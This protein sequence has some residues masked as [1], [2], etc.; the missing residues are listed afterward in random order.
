LLSQVSAEIIDELQAQ[1]LLV[2]AENDEISIR[3]EKIN[4]KAFLLEKVEFYSSFK[5]ARNKIVLLIDD[6]QDIFV[7][8]DIHILKRVMGNMIKN[9]VEEVKSGET[10]TVGVNLPETGKLEIWVH[11]PGYMGR[12]IQLQIFHRSFS[13]KGNG[14][15]L[16]TYS[17]KMLAERYL[18][19]D[20]TFYS[21][22]KFGTKFSLLLNLEDAG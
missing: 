5:M 3:P 6:F 18:N 10:V 17:M 14:R 15:G 7:N 19:G 9:A 2:S 1:K 21:D 22:E 20:I 13:T 11:N 4:L 12:D 16:G 8:A